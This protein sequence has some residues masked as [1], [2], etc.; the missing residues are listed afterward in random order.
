MV[1]GRPMVVGW[2]AALRSKEDAIDERLEPV[3]ERV[4]HEEDDQREEDR[5]RS[6]AGER[7]FL[8]E[9]IEH[10]HGAHVRGAHRSRGIPAPSAG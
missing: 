9:R 2:R 4:E 6:R 8:E 7:V 3:P 10:E 1:M 5:E